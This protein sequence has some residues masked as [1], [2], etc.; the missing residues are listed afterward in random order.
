M[1]LIFIGITFGLLVGAGL[2]ALIIL[3]ALRERKAEQEQE[4]ADD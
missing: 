2:F 3:P 1:G 4:E